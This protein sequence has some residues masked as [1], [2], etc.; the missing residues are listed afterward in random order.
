MP[1]R[2]AR[3]GTARTNQRT[4]I[5]FRCLVDIYK[6]LALFGTSLSL[7]RCLMG[8]PAWACL[9]GWLGM[10]RVEFQHFGIRYDPDLYPNL[11]TRS[12]P[13]SG[14][15]SLHIKKILFIIIKIF[16]T[17]QNVMQVQDLDPSLMF[18]YL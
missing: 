18:R 10:G 11:K 4:V 3:R 16:I 6:Q 17:I 8:L 5:A 1:I 14:S 13:G 9:S 7:L 12:G 15:G 2:T